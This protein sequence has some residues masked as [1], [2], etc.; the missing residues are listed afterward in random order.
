[1]TT[2]PTIQMML[3]MTDLFLNGCVNFV[4]RLKFRFWNSQAL[5]P[6]A[7][8]F[9]VAAWLAVTA[10]PSQLSRAFDHKPLAGS[11]KRVTGWT[12]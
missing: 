11:E 8:R 9:S 5:G 2:A 12:Q 1:M 3:F 4:R 6:C 10:A 7:R